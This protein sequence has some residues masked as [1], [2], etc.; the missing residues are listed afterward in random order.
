MARDS[1]HGWERWARRKRGAGAV[2][3][4]STSRAA[5]SLPRQT[6]TVTCLQEHHGVVARP[7]NDDARAMPLAMAPPPPSRHCAPRPPTSIRKLPD[8]ISQDPAPRDS[9]DA[10]DQT[11]AQATHVRRS[12]GSFWSG[13][14]SNRYKYT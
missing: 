12:G 9:T 14:I 13:I 3:E 10:D 11:N 7:P 5:T 6:S 2:R 4:R 1:T 8:S